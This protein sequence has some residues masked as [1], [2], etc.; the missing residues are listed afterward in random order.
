MSYTDFKEV[1]NVDAGDTTH[2]GSDQLK[3]VLQIFNNKIVSNRRPNIKNPWR[4]SDKIELAAP[5]SL[6]S[7]PT[8]SSY[9]HLVVDPADFHLKVQT[10]TGTLTDLQ[11]FAL[12]TNILAYATGASNVLGDLL[13]NNATKYVRFARGAQ[14]TVLTASATDLVYQKIVDANV[15]SSA[16]IGWSKVSKTGSKLS[17][18]A[19]TNLPTPTNGQV[20]TW[21]TSTSKWKNQTPPGSGTGEANTASNQG[22]GGVGVFNSKVGVDLQFKNINAGSNKVTITNDTVNKEVDIDVAQANLTLS[23]LG[24]SITDSQYPNTP[25]G[26]TYNIDTNTVKHSTTN[27]QGDILVYSTGSSKYVRLARGTNGQVLQSTSSD[28]AWTTPSS[29]ITARGGVALFSGNGITKTFAIA[30]GAGVN[31]TKY[32]VTPASTAANLGNNFPND[33]EGAQWWVTTDS[34]NLTINYGGTAP[35]TGTNN[36]SFA[37]MVIT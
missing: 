34:T 5:A 23:S 11:V 8:T 16:A 3:E 24:G 36:L 25:S 21:D 31:P 35:P 27:A 20:P 2:Y 19:D 28:V 6:P 33:H 32:S 7:N 15:S 18:L 22:V 1:S 4:F 37:W 9:V 10:S 17:D 13:K 14:D 26:K 30:H 29:T 12:E